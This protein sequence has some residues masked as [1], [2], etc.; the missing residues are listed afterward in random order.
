[1]ELVTQLRHLGTEISQQCF[2]PGETTLGSH[3]MVGW[4]G[5]RVGLDTVMEN[6]WRGVLNCVRTNVSNFMQVCVPEFLHGAVYCVVVVVVV[7]IVIIIIIIIII[8]VVVSFIS[9]MM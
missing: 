2:I 8:V 3:L 1:M 7:I 4:V 6:T 5:P 9:R